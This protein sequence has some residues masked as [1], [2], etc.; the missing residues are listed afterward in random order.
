MSEPVEED[1]QQVPVRL[2]IRH[3]KTTILQIEQDIQEMNLK[4]RELEN[5]KA[6]IQADLR[7]HRV[8]T[9]VNYE[10]PTSQPEVNHFAGES[11]ANL[12]KGGQLS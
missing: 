1:P 6:K 10:S 11:A 3:L 5:L 8:K 4:T 7:D 2:H 12:R 9:E